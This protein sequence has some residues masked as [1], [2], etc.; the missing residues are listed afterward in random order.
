MGTLSLSGALPWRLPQPSG[1]PSVFLF[2]S[3][4]WKLVCQDLVSM[5]LPQRGRLSLTGMFPLGSATRKGPCSL[6]PTW[7]R[8]ASL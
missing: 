5:A 2:G 3:D 8:V 6:N 7:L 1:W 4:R